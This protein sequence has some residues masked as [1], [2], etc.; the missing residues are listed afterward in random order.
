MAS[1]QTDSQ[2]SGPFSSINIPDVLVGWAATRSIGSGADGIKKSFTIVDGTGFAAVFAG[3]TTARAGFD[4]V[5]IVAAEDSFVYIR[6]T[7]LPHAPS[8]WKP[9]ID[10]YAI[11]KLERSGWVATPIG[12][13]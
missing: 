1:A 10:S 9:A 2:V 3:R 12:V 5:P 8:R 13:G 11:Y 4:N 6:V 7:V